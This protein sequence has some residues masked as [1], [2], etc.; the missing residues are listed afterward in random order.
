MPSPRFRSITDDLKRKAKLAGKNNKILALNRCCETVYRFAHWKE[1]DMQFGTRQSSLSWLSSRDPVNKQ[2]VL[3]PHH[4]ATNF[5]TSVPSS[6]LPR[7]IPFFRTSTIPCC[8]QTESWCKKGVCNSVANS[9]AKHTKVRI[10]KA[11]L[12]S[13]FD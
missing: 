13:I 6:F 12:P 3:S 1:T 11:T 10:P 5:Y 4:P 9:A 8:G 2:P 7:S